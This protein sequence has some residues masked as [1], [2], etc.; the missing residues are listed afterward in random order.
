MSDSR[1]GFAVVPSVSGADP[2]GRVSEWLT[3][4]AGRPTVTA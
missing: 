2:D 4:R 3:A 1:L